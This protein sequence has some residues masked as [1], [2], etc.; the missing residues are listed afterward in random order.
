MLLAPLHSPANP[1]F[2]A[3][4]RS[5]ND[6]GY[7]FAALSTD[8][9]PIVTADAAGAQ[10]GT[11]LG[12]VSAE[13]AF[14]RTQDTASRILTGAN[15]TTVEKKPAK[16]QA[17][18]YFSYIVPIS[19]RTMDFSKFRNQVSNWLIAR[20]STFDTYTPYLYGVVEG[21]GVDLSES[22]HTVKGDRYAQ[23]GILY[24]LTDADLPRHAIGA[25]AHAADASG[26]ADASGSGS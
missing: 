18:L 2:V 8:P 17:A 9:A 11:S 25:P 26:G 5:L 20:Y 15:A 22:G 3:V 7:T 4:L 10:R 21:Q 13:Q 24:G 1:S 19:A 12:S 23:V 6:A 14:E 16:N